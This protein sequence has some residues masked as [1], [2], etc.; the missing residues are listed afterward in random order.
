LGALQTAIDLLNNVDTSV[1]GSVAKAVNDSFTTLTTNYTN[2]IS[3]AVTSLKGAAT[4]G[5]DTLGEVEVLIDAINTLIGSVT[6]EGS[7]DTIGELLVS[8]RN[9]LTSLQS[10]PT[11]TA[12]EV[13]GAS[14]VLSYADAQNLNSSNKASASAFAVKV[15]GASVAVDTVAVDAA[16]KTV[17]LTL[18]SAAAK[19]DFV[20]VSY[21]DPTTGN[22]TNATQ[23]VNGNDA[24]SFVNVI[25]TNLTTDVAGPVAV[26]TI[27]GISADSGT[28][29]SDYVTNA[30]VQ[31]VTGTLTA[32]LGAGEKVQVSANTT[33]G[34]DGNWFDA[35]VAGT[36]WLAQV[37]LSSGDGTLYVRTVD[38]AGNL[39]FAADSSDF[40]D[41]VGIDYTLDTIKPVAAPGLVQYATSVLSVSSEYGS[42]AGDWSA[43]DALGSPNT[44]TY[45]DNDTAW[46]TQDAEMTPAELNSGWL[47]CTRL[48]DRGQ[49]SRNI[50]RRFCDQSS[51]V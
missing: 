24:F 26:A 34:T 10:T 15:N 17:T 4:S 3:S 40:G 28:S 18:H 16:N 2:A 35:T 29:Q 31:T 33:N 27:S 6:A 20:L 19:G 43:L 45:G 21:V 9:D 47:H 22:D 50:W 42:T 25:A 7:N 32:A 51:V 11:L 41:A 38:A 44:N 49:H 36:Q 30:A 12:V 23:D 46:T 48:C 1:S 39:T 14:V 37:V 8:L 5:A 13:T